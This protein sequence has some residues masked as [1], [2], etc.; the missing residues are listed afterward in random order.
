MSTIVE[1]E[2][3]LFRVDLTNQN[4]P[5]LKALTPIIFSTQMVAGKDFGRELPTFIGR[6]S[7]SYVD[8]QKGTLHP[9]VVQGFFEDNGATKMTF[10]WN[11]QNAFRNPIRHTLMRSAFPGVPMNVDVGVSFLYFPQPTGGSPTLFP[12]VFHF[13]GLSANFWMLLLQAFSLRPPLD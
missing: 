12:R 2:G 13:R 6:F 8:G 9:H 3:V 7:S 11:P 10:V 4:L 5:P 1:S